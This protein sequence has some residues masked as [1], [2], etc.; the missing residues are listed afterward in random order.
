MN[1]SDQIQKRNNSLL[2]KA[3][4][5]VRN[6]ANDQANYGYQLETENIHHNETTEAYYG[7]IRLLSVVYGENSHQVNELKQENKRIT[8]LKY[9][10]DVMNQKLAHA[11]VGIL[12]NLKSEISL[13]LLTTVFKETSRSVLSDFIVLAK[14]AKEEGQLNVSVVLACAALEDGLKK[15]A[16]YNGLAVK[17]NGMMNTLNALKSSGVIKKDQHQILKTYVALR[18]KAFHADWDSIDGADVG[19]II[20]FTEIFLAKHF[21]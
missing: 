15:L 4:A 14:D 3:R 18:N 16:E 21:N 13:G 17:G 10:Q 2:R 12:T 5:I 19:G 6:I 9:R 7:T 20:G 11:L 1:L 8:A